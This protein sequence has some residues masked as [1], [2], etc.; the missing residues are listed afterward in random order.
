MRAVDLGAV[1]GV[2]V[3]CGAL[4][5]LIVPPTRRLAPRVRPYLASLRGADHGAAA[6]AGPDAGSRTTLGRLFGP[7]VLALLR[8]VGGFLER[9]NDEHL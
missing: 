8:R 4:A 1:V 3:C 5:R 9:R 7:P 6:I 2:A